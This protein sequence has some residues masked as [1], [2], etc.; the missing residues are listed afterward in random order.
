MSDRVDKL[1]KFLM[2]FVGSKNTIYR[3]TGGEVAW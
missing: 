3:N 1:I 2:G